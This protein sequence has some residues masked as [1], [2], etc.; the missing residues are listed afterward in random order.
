MNQPRTFTSR[1]SR[2]WALT[3]ALCLVP[4]AMLGLPAVAAAE[5]GCSNAVFRSGPSLRLPDCR[6]YEMVTPPY[7]EG[8][9]VLVGGGAVGASVSI[10]PD[11]SRM[12]GSSLGVFAGAEDSSI[13]L[14]AGEYSG[15]ASYV[16]TRGEDGWEST[17]VV[18][19]AAQYPSAFWVASSA[20]LSKILWDVATPAQVAESG[21]VEGKGVLTLKGFYV[22]TLNGPVVEVGPILPPSVSA[23]E[24]Y[25]EL[26]PNSNYFDFEGASTRDLS[27][28]LYGLDGWHWPGDETNPGAE[29]LYEYLGTGNSA[30][31]LVGVSGGAG[32][33]SLISKCGTKL[34]IESVDGGER[35][36]PAVSEDGSK[37]FFTA[38]A[39]G[40][41]PSV[42]ELYAR[43]D[44]GQPEAH[45]VAISEP[46]RA[47]CSECDTAEGARRPASAAGFSSDGSKAF[48]TTTQ[49][50]LGGGEST[51]LYEYDFEGE[52]GRRIVRV[53]GGDSTVSNPTA[54]VESVLSISPDGS[55]VYFTASG[56]LTRTPNSLGQEAEVG[57]SNVY[58]YERDAEY[59]T[60][61]TVFVL[62]GAD[63]A[64]ETRASQGGRFLVFQSLA[65]LTPDDVSSV[66]QAF[67]YD[68]QTG[69][70]TRVSIGKDGFNED[71]NTG[72]VKNL[73]VAD[74]GAVFFET[75]N[76]LVA[77][78][79]NAQEDVYEYDEGSV[80]LISSGQST[81]GDRLDFISPSGEDVFF[82]T[83]DRL[84]P[85]DAD[86][87]EDTYDARVDGGF[88]EPLPPPSCQADACQ[89]SLSGAPVLLSPGSEFQAGGENVTAPT[90]G[91]PEA[92][93][94]VTKPKAKAKAKAKGR[95]KGSKKKRASGKRGRKA[96]RGGRGAMIGG[97]L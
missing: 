57:R 1:P 77:Q 72:S 5:D 2:G 91:T 9:P 75:A 96:S 6:A 11:G 94:K 23:A 64:G 35:P 89:G 65:Q 31:L 93:T 90:G 56:V 54:G 16:F 20:D 26:G 37:V 32:S 46:S 7:K 63:L 33:T 49:P 67:E 78:A 48:F 53:S 30:P 13:S 3:I 39:C 92:A 81:R 50:L 76:P 88:P 14:A 17:A 18:P 87:Q 24:V 61:R 86:S 12:A 29:S 73:M 41:S 36:S 10:S 79:V 60:G 58:L 44:N 8:F 55:R 19:S 83:F 84:V 71:G 38:L 15:G 47:D 70:F 95:P 45:T 69:G 80:N 97:R 85:K 51:N 62:P 66:A 28:V 82:Q 34:S 52:A 4:A 43:V 22:R 74:D 59:P 40:S 25:R 68:S 27:A 42:Q 21:A